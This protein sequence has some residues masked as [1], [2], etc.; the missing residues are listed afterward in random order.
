M[1]L[2]VGNKSSEISRDELMELISEYEK[3][4]FDL[5]TGD[6][7]YVYKN[8]QQNPNEF[9]IGVDP[10]QRQLREYSKKAVRS[11]TKN[12]LFVLGSVEVFPNEL[13]GLADSITI[14]LHW[15]TLLQVLAEP[16]ETAI[17]RIRDMYKKEKITDSSS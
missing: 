17:K 2:I 10:S 9:Y 11:N 5:G 12:C 13:F 1:E 3:V 6:G 4:Y 16:N 15:G 8:A 14:I 7:R